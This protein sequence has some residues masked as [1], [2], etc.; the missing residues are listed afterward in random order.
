MFFKNIS[1]IKNLIKP[2]LIRQLEMLQV[3]KIEHSGV[4]VV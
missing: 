3:F 2:R 4:Q 1:K